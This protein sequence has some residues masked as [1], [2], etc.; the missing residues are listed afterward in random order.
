MLC[1]FKFYVF[2]ILIIGSPI[3][4]YAQSATEFSHKPLWQD[5]SRTYGYYN[6]QILS[7]ERIQKLFPELSERAK[8]SQMEFDLVFRPS[9]KNIENT[10]KKTFKADWVKFQSNMQQQIKNMLLTSQ[11]K[12][13]QADAFIDQILLRAKGQ[14]ESPVLETLL[15]YDPTFQRNPVEE[16]KRG[17][18]NTYRT[19]GHPKAKGLDFQIEY[20]K[21]WAIREGKRPNIIQFF[22]S[23]NGRGPVYASIMDRDF[24]QEAPDQLTKNEFLKLKSLEGSKEL[25]SEVFSESSLREMA[26]GMGM[27]NVRN[28][29]TKR[30]VLDRWPGAMLEFIGERQRVDIKI[31]M[32]NRTYLVIYKNYMVFLQCQV[33][34]IPSENA[35]DFKK[36]ITTNIPLFRYLA[37]SL[38]LQSQY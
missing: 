27:A 1:R 35:K 16:L 4:L 26:N 36:R 18:K 14:I 3:F 13:Q 15:A 23:N 38:V 9:Y 21:S 31:T 34:K 30:V 25:A 10:L 33:G 24:I 6:G 2:A 12:R 17:F 19:K 7:I 22:G 32:Y 8:Q 29:T 11:L 20:P 5:L 37:N 28:I